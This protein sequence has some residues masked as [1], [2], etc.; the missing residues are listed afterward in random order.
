MDQRESIRRHHRGGRGCK[1]G[2]SGQRSFAYGV[3]QHAHLNYTAMVFVVR[4]DGNPIGVAEPA[5]RIIRGWTR[6]ADRGGATMESSWPRRSRGRRFSALLLRD[7]RSARC[8]W[9][10]LGFMACWR[11]RSLERTREIGV[12][13]ALGPGRGRLSGWWRQGSAAGACRNRGRYRRGTCALGV[14]ERACCSA[15]DRGMP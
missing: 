14:A 11:I 12:R 5:R 7:S 2:R 6:S 15:W 13:V 9:R 4:T 10:R 8:C 1:G 3:L